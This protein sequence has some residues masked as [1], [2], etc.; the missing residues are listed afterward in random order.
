MS[1]ICGTRYNGRRIDHHVSNNLTC[2]DSSQ[3]WYHLSCGECFCRENP[4]S[5][6]FPKKSLSKTGSKFLKKTGAKKL[7]FQRREKIQSLLSL[8]SLCFSWP[9]LCL[10][11]LLF[12]S[13][14]WSWLAV[15]AT[16]ATPESPI[17]RFGLNENTEA[18][19][20]IWVHQTSIVVSYR[21]VSYRRINWSL[22]S[23]Q[24]VDVQ[25]RVRTHPNVS[26]EQSIR[27]GG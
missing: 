1:S 14:W 13:C 19:Q 25:D 23:L 6:K 2:T 12:L 15:E 4:S 22:Y 7:R 21:I 9:R 24:S 18:K 27:S 17:L 3:V 11:L 20:G 8:L 10:W 16:L 26:T 5:P